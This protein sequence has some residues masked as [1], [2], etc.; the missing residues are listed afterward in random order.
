MDTRLILKVGLLFC[1]LEGWTQ[2]DTIARRL[3]EPLADVVEARAWLSANG[4]L[5]AGY[6]VAWRW[7]WF[8]PPREYEELWAQ[9]QPGRPCP[10]TLRATPARGLRSL[11]RPLG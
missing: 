11:G 4:Y 10:V 1:I 7:R 9:L 5:E 3:N 8:D 2:A 6:G